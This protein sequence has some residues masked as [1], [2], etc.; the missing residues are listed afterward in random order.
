M[1]FKPF[2]T[3]S[4][5]R[6]TSTQ[7]DLASGY[8]QIEISEKYI[9]K[10]AF[11]DAD[12]QLYEFNRAGYGLTVLPSA[13][14]RAIRGALG[15]PNEDVC[16]WLDDILIAS[17]TWE[18]H[19]QTLSVVLSRLLAAGLSVN[20]AKCVFGAASQDFLGMVI[21]NSGLKASTIQTRSDRENAPTQ[22]C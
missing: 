4:K 11:R 19:L 2:S 14:T 7:L 12:G 10:T 13:F 22:K 3:D 5:G 1:T 6:N 15:P 21:D 16:S 9:H 20:F 18:E 17:A 8:H